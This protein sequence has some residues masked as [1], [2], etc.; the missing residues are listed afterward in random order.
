MIGIDSVFLVVLMTAASHTGPDGAV[1]LSS[2]NRLVVLLGSHI[3][4]ASTK[5]GFI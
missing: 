4:M 3:S 2:A 1:A 5:T